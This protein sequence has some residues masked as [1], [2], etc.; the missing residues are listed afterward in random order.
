MYG[1]YVNESLNSLGRRLSMINNHRLTLTWRGEPLNDP[2]IWAHERGEFMVTFRA[3][4]LV[5]STDYLEN[6]SL[7]EE[8]WEG[9]MPESFWDDLM[10]SGGWTYTELSRYMPFHKP[11]P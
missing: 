6:P 11:L 4:R 2:L 3:S 10:S 1:N 5:A 7:V 9:E 8:I